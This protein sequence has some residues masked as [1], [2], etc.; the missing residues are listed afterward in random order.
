M[1]KFDWTESQLRDDP[2]DS[3]RTVYTRTS[4][5]RKKSKEAD[6]RDRAER[7]TDPLERWAYLR[8]S[9]PKEEDNAK[10]RQNFKM[11]WE[12]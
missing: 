2:S 6:V 11:G 12:Q 4:S 8:A 3:A 10:F 7:F 1:K 5:R 9:L